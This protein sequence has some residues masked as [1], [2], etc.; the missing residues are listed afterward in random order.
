MIGHV[1]CRY[2]KSDSAGDRTGT[3]EMQVGAYWRNLVNTIE[4]FVC[5]LMSNY[6]NRLLLLLG[7]IAV[8]RIRRCRPS[9]VVCRSVGL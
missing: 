6:F 4:P 9:S 2:T 1:R 8:L 5:G 7:R 3:V